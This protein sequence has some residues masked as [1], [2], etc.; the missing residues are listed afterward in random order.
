MYKIHSEFQLNGDKYSAQELNQWALDKRNSKFEFEVE[1]ALFLLDWLNDSETIQVKTS[2]TTGTSKIIGIKKTAMVNS[3]IATSDFFNLK[4]GTS[5]LCCLPIKYIAGKMMLV[6][7]MVLGW[8]LDIV[9]PSS[10]PLANCVKNYDF[11]AMVPLQVENSLDDLQSVKTIL[12]GGAKVTN[13]L[14]VKLMSIKCNAYES[15]SMTETVTHIA[16]KKIGESNFRVL[17]DVSIAIDDRN[18]LIIKAPKLNPEII[19]TNDIVELMSAQEFIWKG[20]IDNVINSGGIK[21]FPEQIEEKLLNKIP[22]RFF[23]GGVPDEKLGEKVVLFIEGLAYQ[24]DSAVFDELDKYEKPKEIFFFRSFLETETG[25]I[26][27][28]E[29]IQNLFS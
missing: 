4:E 13:D 22:S 20:R 1:C 9:E 12:I 27:R 8:N 19:V 25:K 7:A 29:I 11:V 18:C 14:A 28:K 24:L 26:K 21:L 6:R 17:P 2:G 3:A 16:L 15:Y 10:N 5:A 23:I